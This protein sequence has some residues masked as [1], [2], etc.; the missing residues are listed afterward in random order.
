M[1]ILGGFAIAG[2]LLAQDAAA[3][4]GPSTTIQ[5]RAAP[6]ARITSFKAEPDS[7]HPGQT[8]TLTLGG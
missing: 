6:P 5:R 3:P 8:A 1:R 7:I 2:V 4:P